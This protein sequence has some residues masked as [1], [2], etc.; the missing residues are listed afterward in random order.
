V[1]TDPVLAGRRVF[2]AAFGGE[3]EEVVGGVEEVN[4]A[5][6]RGVC[7]E[8]MA[9]GIAVK[10]ADA[11]AFADIEAVGGV[12]VDGGVVFVLFGRE[13]DVEVVIEI[14]AVGRIPVEFPAHALFEGF[15]FFEAG[16]GDDGEGGV[17]RGKVVL[18][19]VKVIGPEGAVFAAFAPA[20]AEHKVVDEDLAFA[21]KHF[22]E[23]DFAGGAVEDVFLIN[24]DPGELTALLGELVAE[25]GEF[26][27]FEEEFFA[28]GEPLFLVNDFV[29]FEFCCGDFHGAFRWGGAWIT[30]TL[31]GGHGNSLSGLVIFS[32]DIGE[33][34]GGFGE[35]DAEVFHGLNDDLRDGEVAKPFVIG[36][37]DIPRRM[38]GAALVEDVFVSGLVA[39][40]VFALGVIGFADFPA[41]GGIVEALF[42]AVELFLF[43]DVEVE[44]EDVG[45]VGGEALLEVVD[46][47]IA[48]GPD[49]F[50]NEVVYADDEDVFVVGAVEDD[51]FAAF[52]G[53]AFD[54]PQKIVGEFIGGGFFEAGDATS[55]RVHGTEDVADDAVLAAGVGGL[56]A[57]EE[58]LFL[59]GVKSELQI[60]HLLPEF[61]ELRLG[62]LLIC[63]PGGELG[64][65][66]FEPDVAAE[67]YA[68]VF[69]V[70][71]GFWT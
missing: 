10:G 13:G 44:F 63:V 8:D 59:L 12:V 14:T 27:F 69:V 50:G 71:H 2:V 58:G 33:V 6:V 65:E 68:K 9:A 55:L 23:G 17:A 20:G 16:A 57:D 38:F 1:I 53:L 36:G 41:A 30:Y 67:F 11:F 32:A 39:G 19:A 48:L 37:D 22:G 40:P 35:L 51:D 62:G 42:E 31:F 56:E 25:F 21:G 61:F 45:A 15:D 3:V 46:L 29:F 60:V 18:E 34:D 66:I 49:F 70:I 5:F 52:G 43:A 24:P 4:A 54:A 47:L 64:I 28:G 7:V 26:F